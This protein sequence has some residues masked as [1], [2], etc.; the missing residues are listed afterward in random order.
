MS[1]EGGL[2]YAGFA[3]V[4]DSVYTMGLEVDGDNE[5]VIC[6]SAKDGS[7]KWT[8]NIGQKFE[9]RW[10]DGPRAT[11][12][13]D[14]DF[15]YAMSGKGT[16]ACVS[17]KNGKVVWTVEMTELGGRVPFWGY[18][19]SVLVDGDNVICTPGGKQGAIAAI[20][21]KSGKVVWQT[22]DFTDGAQYSSPVKAVINNQPQY[23]QLTMKSLVAVSPENGKVIWK[24][25]WPGRTAVIPTPI[26]SK[27]RV[28]ISSGYKVGCKAVE[29]SA[30][31]QVKEI[32]KNDVMT[33][34][35]GGVI[36]VNGHLYGYS[37][38]RRNGVDLSKPGFG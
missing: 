5:F 25:D 15:C 32:Y 7:K 30:D 38:S 24:S 13:V 33:N 21:K 11:P 14:G 3:V 19:E 36:L 17:N 28:Y 4:G 35:H 8:A 22:E 31:N 2:G 20:N 26:V 27:N 10:G 9:N 1:E 18:C 34:H 6:L 23:I 16:L 29:I 12:T 37:D